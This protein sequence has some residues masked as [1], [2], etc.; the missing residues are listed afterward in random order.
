M[1]N[2]LLPL[3]LSLVALVL[4]KDTAAPP[5]ECILS[6]KFSGDRVSQR[7]GCPL[8]MLSI[9]GDAIG[10]WTPRSANMFEKP[11]KCPA[12]SA[13]DMDF[14]IN[15]DMSCHVSSDMADLGWQCAVC[16]FKFVLNV[17]TARSGPDLACPLRLGLVR[18]VWLLAL[19]AC[20]AFL[21]EACFK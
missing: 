7:S 17:G 5:V 10:D 15:N 21:V 16:T 4:G 12:T 11:V 1:L 2:F 19:V 6:S 9:V 3:E 13:D 14:H 18:V 20:V 8:W